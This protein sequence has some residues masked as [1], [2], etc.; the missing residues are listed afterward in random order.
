MKTYTTKSNALRAAQKAGID[1]K[2][3]R[4]THDIAAGTW[5][6]VPNEASDVAAQDP[7][8]ILDQT[9]QAEIDAALASAHAAYEAGERG[10]A[11]ATGDLMRD[12]DE[13]GEDDLE[14]PEFLRGKKPA[15]EAI[16]RV[17]PVAPDGVLAVYNEWVEADPDEFDADAMLAYLTR[18]YEAGREAAATKPPRRATG[19]RTAEPKEGRGPNKRELA[20]ALL[21]R[22]N[23]ANA[24][25]IMDATGWPAVSVPAL[26]KASRLT[27][28]QEKD[29][30]VT[31]YYG[32][33]SSD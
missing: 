6:W 23:G 2:T 31:R 29:G 24:R 14:I 20:A 26:A 22:P 27:L 30:K 25:E 10:P 18:A 11:N 9:P 15:A 5:T 8:T 4:I 19:R 3:I 12:M 28:R 7:E 1:I 32:T 21:T 16:E 13:A 33:A 17:K